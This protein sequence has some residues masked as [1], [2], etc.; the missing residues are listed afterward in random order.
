[1]CC[2][3]GKTYKQIVKKQITSYH[4]AGICFY[5]REDENAELTVVFVLLLHYYHKAEL[6]NTVLMESPIK[7]RIVIGIAKTVRNKHNNYNVDGILAVHG[8]SGCDI[9]AGGFCIGIKEPLLKLYV[10]ALSFLGFLTSP[11]EAVILQATVFMSVCYGQ[12]N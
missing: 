5:Y 4:S 1:M 6:T 12:T 3:G 10:M 2:L 7:G 11:L 9:V 8:F